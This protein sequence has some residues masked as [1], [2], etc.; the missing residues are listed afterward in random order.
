M[1]WKK[2]Y[3][4]KT[5]MFP[6]AARKKVKQLSLS[7]RKAELDKVALDVSVAMSCDKKTARKVAVTF[8]DTS[9]CHPD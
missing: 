8:A 5:P 6:A 2:K 9:N 1:K 3:W 4:Q 7:R